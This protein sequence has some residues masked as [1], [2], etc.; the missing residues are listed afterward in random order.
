MPVANN[1]FGRGVMQDLSKSLGR[2]REWVTLRFETLLAKPT[3]LHRA[4]FKYLRTRRPILLVWRFAFVARYED[5]CHV[6]ADTEQFSVIYGPKVCKTTG[7]FVVG[8]GDTREYH[9]L[10]TLMNDATDPNDETAIR[11][12]V[13]DRCDSLLQQAAST[14]HIDLAGGFARDVAATVA[15]EYLGVRAPLDQIMSWTRSIFREIFLD[16]GDDP[17]MGSKA[18]L[19]CFQLEDYLGGLIQQRSSEIQNGEPTPGDFLSR[20]IT[21]NLSLPKSLTLDGVYRIVAGTFV[22]SVDN[23]SNSITNAFDYLLDHKGP[24]AEAHLA[25]A[26]NDDRRLLGIMLEALRF[27]PQ[28]PFLIRRCQK[29]CILAPWT[30]RATLIPANTLVLAGTACAMFDAEKFPHPEEFRTDRTPSDYLHFGRGMHECFGAF[31]A[32]AVIPATA[33]ALL[34]RK[35]LRRVRGRDGRIRYDGAFSDHLFVEFD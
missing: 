23:I 22:G 24:M 21:L 3:W 30:S 33:K 4:L 15:R 13:E 8:M 25:A 28:N 18:Q 32:N 27:Y 29:A 9:D 20:L 31:I 1:A 26:N 5:V 34:K 35:R 17:S 12:I 14:G 19:A 6:L 7:P 2:A 16:F 10:R 11:A